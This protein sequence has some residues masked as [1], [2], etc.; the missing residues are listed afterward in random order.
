MLP[1]AGL[2]VLSPFCAEYLIGSISIRSLPLLPFLIPLYGAAAVLIRETTR[3]TGRG[4]R[5]MLLLGGAF[6]VFQAGIVDA[7][8]FNPD[9]AELSVDGAQVPVLHFSAVFGLA[10]VLNHVMLSIG[11]P[12][13]LIEAL[14][15]DGEAA[16]WLGRI[17]LV[18][19]A[20][21]YLAGSLLIGWDNWVQEQFYPS[22]IQLASAAAAIAVLIAL[23]FA[24]PPASPRTAGSA[25]AGPGSALD[26]GGPPRPLLVGLATAGLTGGYFFIPPTWP[27]LI[28]GL[29]LIG[30]LGMLVARWSQTVGWNG[31]H[32]MALAAGAL[33]TGAWGA[34]IV[35]S[36]TGQTDLVTRVGNALFAL[37]IWALLA[38]SGRRF[39][40]R[41]QVA[42]TRRKAARPDLDRQATGPAASLIAASATEV[43]VQQH[44]SGH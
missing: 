8:L 26:S 22:P 16:P 34:F 27:G 38:W 19:T 29:V 1:V 42:S 5:T 2:L 40:P 13:A 36:F 44:V 12:I 10:F 11:A 31:R 4:W 9:Y 15:P 35:G 43:T 14:A 39:Q 24:R 25:P 23:A 6:G 28:L 7:S 30:L 32:R 3:R 37:V 17:G 33:F 18:I 41:R 20:L 21:S